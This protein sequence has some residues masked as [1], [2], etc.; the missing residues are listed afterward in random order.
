MSGSIGLSTAPFADAEKTDLR[1]FMGYPAYGAGASGFQGWRFFE[2]YGTLEFRMNNASP[3]EY[4]V[5]R[6]YLS[7]LYTLESAI[8]GAGTNMGTDEAAVW[9]RNKNELRD[10]LAQFTNWRRTLCAFFGV[11]PGPE[12]S[13]GGGTIT[14]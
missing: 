12:L 8:L 10:R 3:S 5:T 14:I 9:K 4:Q 11:P 2:A 1:R 6:Q 7:Q 13:A